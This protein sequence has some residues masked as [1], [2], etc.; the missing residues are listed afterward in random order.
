MSQK[1]TGVI[2]LMSWLIICFNRHLDKNHQHNNIMKN[3]LTSC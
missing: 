1:L 2:D 3:R